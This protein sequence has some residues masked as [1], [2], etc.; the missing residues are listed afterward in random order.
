[1]W[2]DL[3]PRGRG[4]A[5]IWTG[6][7]LAGPA[8]SRV[9]GQPGPVAM[10]AGPEGFQ[11]RGGLGTWGPPLPPLSALTVSCLGGRAPSAQPGWV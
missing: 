2:P 4:T 1:M 6:A 10:T 3:V 8:G 7:Q 9:R 11:A 5:G